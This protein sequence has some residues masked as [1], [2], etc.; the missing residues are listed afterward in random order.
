MISLEQI[1]LLESRI[2]KAVKVIEMLREE[3]GALK[4]SVDVAQKRMQE[5]EALVSEFKA[6]QEE[7]EQSLLR[8]IHNLDRLEDGM[9]AGAPPRGGGSPR[10]A[11]G[12]TPALRRSPRGGRRGRRSAG[13]AGLRRP[14]LAAGGWGGPALR[15]P[16]RRGE[17]AGAGHLLKEP[18]SG[19]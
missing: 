10:P 9:E 12:R 19:E 8:A 17:E 15:G 14:R 7:I 4:R 11:P 5:L 13:A 18:R 3:N 16:A 2:T 1:R 6:D